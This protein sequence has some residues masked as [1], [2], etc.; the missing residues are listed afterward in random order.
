M[1]RPQGQGA[2]ERDMSIKNSSD[3]IGNGTRD[4]RACSPVPQTTALPARN[5]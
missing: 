3:T 4:L 5:F 2:V 1:S